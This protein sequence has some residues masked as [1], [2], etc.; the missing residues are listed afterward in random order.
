MSHPISIIDGKTIIVTPNRKSY[1]NIL[2][3]CKSGAENLNEAFNDNQIFREEKIME[4]HCQ[5]MSYNQMYSQK[6][7]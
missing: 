5:V 2:K 3:S 6:H 1:T 7:T 4:I